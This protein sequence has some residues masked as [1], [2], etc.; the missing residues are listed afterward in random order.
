VSGFLR[1]RWPP[2]SYRLVA[3]AVIFVR[4][5]GGLVASRCAGV[6]VVRPSAGVRPQPGGDGFGHGAPGVLD[7]YLRIDAVQLVQVDVVSAEPAQAGVDGGPDASGRPLNV[8]PVGTPGSV[9]VTAPAF[10][11]RIARWR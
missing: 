11:A 5:S 3:A 6:R 4:L 10:V 1:V 9:P 7:R 2:A 8:R